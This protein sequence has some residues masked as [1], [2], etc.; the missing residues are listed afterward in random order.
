MHRYHH[1]LYFESAAEI[2][3]LIT[4]GKYF[5][6]KSKK[7]TNEAI[8]SLINLRPSIA[9]L[10]KG[11]EIVDVE[12]DDV[13]IGDILQVKMGESIPVD[14]VVKSGNV[15]IDE[16]AITGESLPVEKNAGDKVIGA[17]INKGNAFSFE[18]TNVGSDIQDYRA[19]KRC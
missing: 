16:S 6:T 7:K 18:V 1:N 11:D 8:S 13:K 12:I 3:T 19:C 9:H 17:T 4:L 15:I 2:L 5:E 10:I 14:G